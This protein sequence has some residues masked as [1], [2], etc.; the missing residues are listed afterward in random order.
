M[1][2]LLNIYVY[3]KDENEQKY[4]YQKTKEQKGKMMKNLSI[5]EH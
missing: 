3:L 2:K 5:L 1:K 4:I